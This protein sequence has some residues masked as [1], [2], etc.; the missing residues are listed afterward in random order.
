MFSDGGQ[1][2]GGREGGGGLFL[3]NEHWALIVRPAISRRQCPQL[4][5]WN[6]PGEKVF[7][8]MG[9]EVITLKSTGII[10]I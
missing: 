5:G 10:L 3:G 2:E 1:A 6:Q 7:V 9:S 4:A 8:V